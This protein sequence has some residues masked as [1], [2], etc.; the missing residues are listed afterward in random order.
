MDYVDTIYWTA[1]ETYVSLIVPC[2][3]AMRPLLSRRFPTMFGE[4]SQSRSRNKYAQTDHKG[5]T[6]IMSST[7]RSKAGVSSGHGRF[8]KDLSLGDKGRG[9]IFTGVT[10]GNTSEEQLVLG[11]GIAV[12]TKTHIEASNKSLDE[13]MY[14]PKGHEN[15]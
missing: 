5:N 3:P 14:E 12:N 7:T 4:D 13:S 15:C 10:T 8:L 11:K 6:F 2:L 1:I 9:T